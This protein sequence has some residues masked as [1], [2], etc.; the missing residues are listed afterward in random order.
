MK[1]VLLFGDS[2]AHGVGGQAG[3]WTDKLKT[4]LNGQLWDSDRG[5][6]LY[7]LGVSGDTARDVLGRFE[8]ELLA[9]APHANPQDTSVIF[10]AGVNDSKATNKSDNFLSDADQYATTIQAFIRIAKG[11][12]ANII[13]V[14][15]LPV[16]EARSNPRH[17]LGG[18]IAYFFN[19]RI[20]QFEAALVEV[21]KK[22]HI[23]CVSLFGQVPTDWKQ[24][25]LADGLHPNDAGH[26]WIFEQVRPKLKAILRQ[27]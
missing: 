10:A 15:L 22:E 4:T 7:E 27:S 25:Y 23:A 12:A 9:R 20:K 3:G 2:I 26:E 16:D 11:H 5:T 8:V 6:V 21:C 24:N 17:T 1:T 19:R 13:C 14:G 18:D